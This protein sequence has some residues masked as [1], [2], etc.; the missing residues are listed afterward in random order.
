MKHESISTALAATSAL[1]VAPSGKQIMRL[2]SDL[3]TPLQHAK[4]LQEDA[5]ERE[6]LQRWSAAWKAIGEVENRT[7]VHRGMPLGDFDGM[8]PRP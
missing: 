7:V 3:E 2:A 5:R 4:R 1:G 6:H 8:G